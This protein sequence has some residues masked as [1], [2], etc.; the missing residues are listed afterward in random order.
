MMPRPQK[1]LLGFILD[2]LI[3]VVLGRL[4]IYI[5]KIS[6]MTTS[7]LAAGL[8]SEVSLDIPTDR[9]AQDISS[10]REFLW[11]PF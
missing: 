10:R 3:D 9:L 5:Q 2:I 7:A 6:I 8:I 1:F 11:P 4:E